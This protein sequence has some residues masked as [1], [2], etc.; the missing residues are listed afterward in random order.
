MGIASGGTQV[1]DHQVPSLV[2]PFRRGWDY[3]HAVETDLVAP[4]ED[5]VGLGA[6]DLHQSELGGGPLEAVFGLV[7]AGAAQ[8][9]ES[10]RSGDLDEHAAGIPQAV[11]TAVRVSENAHVGDRRVRIEILGSGGKEWVGRVFLR[12]MDLPA[13]GS[14][15]LDH[16]VVH[17]E[18]PFMADLQRVG[19]KNGVGALNRPLM[20]VLCRG[21]VQGSGQ[22]DH[23]GHCR[24]REKQIGYSQLMSPF[25]RICPASTRPRTLP[26]GPPW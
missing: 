1:V 3:T 15:V 20:F 14:N 21:Q 12:L 13:K 8:P 6:V 25:R 17:Q 2:P 23:P 4:F 16:V 18:L 22:K 11:E 19:R 5:V 26:S 7:V 10:G 9:V 24:P